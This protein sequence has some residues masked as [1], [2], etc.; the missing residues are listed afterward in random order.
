VT[1]ALLGADEG[2]DVGSAVGAAVTGALLGADEGADVGSAVG[3]AVTGVLDGAVEGASVDGEK[4]GN[5]MGLS[6]INEGL[7]TGEEEGAIVGNSPGQ[8]KTVGCEVIGAVEGLMVGHVGTIV[9]IGLIEIVAGK[10]KGLVEGA[11]VTLTVGQWVGLHSAAG[12]AVGF[13]TG[14]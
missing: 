9:G 14:V 11:G 10:S 5:D 6:E 2:A 7:T 4:V 1:G 3:A 13:E 8:I 12:F